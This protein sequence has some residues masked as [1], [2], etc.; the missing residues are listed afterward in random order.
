MFLSSILDSKKLSINKIID[1]KVDDKIIVKR[2]NT[3]SDIENRKD[4]NEQVIKVTIAKYIS[5]TKPVSDLYKTQK[6]SKYEAI[7][8]PKLAPPPTNTAIA[9]LAGT[10]SSGCK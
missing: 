1:I 3:R 4:D 2:I 5:E 7:N 9:E 10:I 8:G 6:S